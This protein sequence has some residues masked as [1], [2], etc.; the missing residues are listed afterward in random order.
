M[1]TLPVDAKCVTNAILT[2]GG[3][4]KQGWQTATQYFH[5]FHYPGALNFSQIEEVTVKPEWA[6]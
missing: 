1:T 5:T 2:R 4:I 6:K 3:R